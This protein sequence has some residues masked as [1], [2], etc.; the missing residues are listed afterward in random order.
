MGE[1]DFW[2]KSLSESHWERLSKE[3]NQDNEAAA[4]AKPSSL[5]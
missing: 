2:Y 4:K 5:N 1:K 3:M